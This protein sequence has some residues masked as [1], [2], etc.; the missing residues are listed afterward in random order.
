MG[1]NKKTFS[2]LSDD[3]IWFL[4]AGLNHNEPDDEVIIFNYMESQQV[5]EWGFHNLDSLYLL[6]Q[7]NE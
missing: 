2:S 6:K 4:G 5:L 1:G 3:G 7:F